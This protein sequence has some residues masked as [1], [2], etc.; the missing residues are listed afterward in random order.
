MY[1]FPLAVSM[2]TDCTAANLR[3][4]FLSIDWQ[5]DSQQ[6]YHVIVTP[7]DMVGDT[8]FVWERC[9][10]SH[11]AVGTPDVVTVCVRVKRALS[12]KAGVLWC[13]H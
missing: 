2:V 3:G 1:C 13:I 4:K 12:S 6:P 10:M 9:S 8:C 11:L 5:N 7:K